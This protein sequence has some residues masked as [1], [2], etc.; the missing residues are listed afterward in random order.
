ML[1]NYHKIAFRNLWKNR[2]F[3]L[4]NSVGMGIGMTAVVLMGLYIAHELS[5][6]MWELSNRGMTTF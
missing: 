1:I 6:E 4:L 2:L 3:S 5:Y